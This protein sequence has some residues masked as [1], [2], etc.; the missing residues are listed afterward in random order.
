MIRPEVMKGCTI[1]C[2]KIAARVAV[3]EK[4]CN[5]IVGMAS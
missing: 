3:A 1:A 4:K 5:K 2:V